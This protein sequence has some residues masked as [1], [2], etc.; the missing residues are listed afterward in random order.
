MNDAL[1]NAAIDTLLAGN[2]AESPLWLQAPPGVQ[3]DYLDGYIDAET[4]WRKLGRWVEA[5]ERP[6]LPEFA[7]EGGQ[8]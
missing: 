5:Q 4:F 2:P 7:E 6:A 8:T 3:R 1:R